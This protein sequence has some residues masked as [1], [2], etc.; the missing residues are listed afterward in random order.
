MYAG[1]FKQLDPGNTGIITGEK[2]RSTFEK[3]GLPPTILGEIWQISDP[4]NLGFLT[5]FGFCHAMRLIGYTQAGQHPTATLADRPGPLPKFADLELSTPT[6]TLN[7]QS[8]SS[9]FMQTQPSSIIPQNTTTLQYKPQD[10]ISVVSAQDYQKFSQLFIKTV[11]S[12]QGELGGDQARDIFLKAK[13]PTATLGQIW[14][15]VDRFNLGKLNISGFVIAMH[16]IHGLLS[17]QI[18]QL[19]PFL[20]QSIWQSVEHPSDQQV[21]NANNSRQTSRSSVISQ[22]TTVRHSSP[23]SAQRDPSSGGEWV[24]TSAMVQQYLNIFNSLDKSKSGQLN[25]DQVASFLMTSKLGQQDL[26]TIW[27]LSDFQNTGIFHPLE[28]SIALFLVNKRLAGETLPNIVPGSLLSSLKL[29]L[30]NPSSSNTV[31]ETVGSPQVSQPQLAQPV[32]SAPK[33]NMDDLAD[34]FAASASPAQSP[35][36]TMENRIS[37]SSELTHSSDL[38]KVRSTLTGS[39]KPT[40]TFGQQLLH[41]QHTDSTIKEGKLNL[42]GDDVPTNKKDMETPVTNASPV[43][44][45]TS[46]TQQEHKVINYDALRSVPP[47]PVPRS[48]EQ[49]TQ[50]SFQDRVLASPTTGSYQDRSTPLSLQGQVVQDQSLGDHTP[51]SRLATTHVQNDDLLAD[52]NPEISGQ[53]SQASTDIVN[54]SNQVKSLTTQTTALHEKKSRAEQE[55]QKILATKKDIEAK[56]GTL[57]LS[58]QNEVK[59]VEQV[60]AN[61]GTA[62]E[63]TEALRSEASISEAKL[64]ALSSQLH[65]KQ[66]FMEDLQKQNSTLTEKLGTMNAEIVDLENQVKSHS[67]TNEQLTKQVNVK[68]SQVQVALVKHQDLKGKLVELQSHHDLMTKDISN[69]EAEYNRLLE[70]QP[71]LEQ[72]HQDIQQKHAKLRE[73]M[74]LMSS[75]VENQ[76]SVLLGLSQDV[77]S[78]QKE[79]DSASKNSQVPADHHKG[80]LTGTGIAVGAG[81]ATAGAIGT[82]ILSHD[83]ESK[84]SDV[85][86]PNEFDSK[87]VIPDKGSNAESSPPYEE[88]ASLT[89]KDSVPDCATNATGP[90][91]VATNVA[92][93]ETPITSPNNSEF[94]FT[95]HNS[96]ITIPG[97]LVGVE[98]TD[99]LTSSVQNNA[100]LSVRDDNIDVSDREMDRE[101]LSDGKLGY[102][103]SEFENKKEGKSVS[104]MDTNEG[105][106][107]SSGVESFEI[108]NAEDAKQ[109]NQPSNVGEATDIEESTTSNELSKSESNDHP[110]VSAIDKEFPPIKELDYDESSSEAESNEDNFDDAKDNFGSSPFTTKSDAPPLPE[111]VPVD[112]FDSAFDGLEPATP[113]VSKGNEQLFTD[114]FDNLEAAKVDNVDEEFPEN[115]FSFSEGF[116]SEG[117]VQLKPAPAGESQGN[118]GADEWEQLFAGFG[119]SQTNTTNASTVE[120]TVPQEISTSNNLH[121]SS[122]EQAI[123]ELVGMGFDKDVATNALEK[124]NWNL[125]KATNYLLDNA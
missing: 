62:K 93:G 21:D 83:K 37:S 42:L 33:S 124:E 28:F 101:T 118:E 55:L 56:L 88:L 45:D 44:A 51:T 96:G 99:S 39:F 64:N 23:S 102:D 111:K 115:D 5:Q 59:S 107:L 123:H 52:A 109:A 27:D 78:A 90:S 12:T 49:S 65:E 77:E 47:P 9:S 125:A 41:N 3:S 121:D 80:I 32:K 75:K 57:R 20:P 38:P 29:A 60:E 119:N 53:L 117:G 98:R 54:V 82:S 43:S 17:G 72:A 92:E 50:P 10:P 122:K 73:Q 34:I 22:Q 76:K 116:T 30:Q 14:N 95:D 13:L 85:D 74:D 48:L 18:K 58:Y 110:E 105:D 4:K 86:E 79:F 36:K 66:L 1:L 113:E 25:P 103:Q 19:P 61:L 84:A 114:E 108:V 89:V 8:T 67:T 71:K 106:K 120:Q 91:S 97:D 70:E 35:V 94:Q 6:A 63:E 40:S 16:L 7:P 15:L 46:K 87:N 11:G 100:A 112:D 81:I 26:A 24:A 2:A 104:D 31:P 68:K 69:A